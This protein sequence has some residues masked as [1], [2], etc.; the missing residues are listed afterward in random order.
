MKNLIG[1]LLSS[2]FLTVIL[3]VN[4]QAQENYFLEGK[5]LAQDGSPALL[6]TISILEGMNNSVKETFYADQNG[7]F[8]IALKKG[9]NF[10]RAA[11]INHAAKEFGVLVED[12]KIYHM[13]I[14]LEGYSYKDTLDEVSI[15]GDFNNFNFST[16][17]RMTK[18]SDG[19]F[20][21]AIDWNKDSLAYQLIGTTKNNRSINGTQSD[22]YEYDG[23]GDYKSI[24]KVKDGVAKII[25]DPKKV[26]RGDKKSEVVFENSP[27]ND[28]INQLGNEAQVY[29]N[30]YYTEMEEFVG[31]G[32]DRENFKFDFSD[33][34]NPIKEKMNSEKGLVRQVYQLAYALSFMFGNDDTTAALKIINDIP[35][36]SP[37]WMINPSTFFGLVSFLPDDEKI[38]KLEEVVKVTDD[39]AF[40]SYSLMMLYYSTVEEERANYYYDKL[41]EEYPNSQAAKSLKYFAP[42]DSKI[43]K[44]ASVPDFKVTNFDEPDKTFSN[45]DM[46]GK[47]YMI[48]FWATWCGPCVAEMDNLHKAYGLFKDKGFQIIS[49][50]FDASP[51]DVKKFRGDKYKM[52]WLHSFVEG[53]F[54]SEIAAA[55]EVKGIP[56]PILVDKDGTILAV[57]SPLRGKNLFNTLKNIF[58]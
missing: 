13:K 53:G 22:A 2:F 42:R 19:T 43:K 51:D 33:Y 45:I 21:L 58:R 55:F 39:D 26:I 5:I 36:S 54:K 11:G 32:G 20:S 57:D 17:R 49:L 14:Q 40:A 28:L 35:V 29:T 25:F 30:K 52:P 37:L 48:D 41:I 15:I 38:S 44:G 3:S 9:F 6:S 50:S 10:F 12:T 16:G 31:G 47:V 56:K 1:F 7:S 27:E 8:K 46:Y 34:L 23:T 4:A 18:E 24:I